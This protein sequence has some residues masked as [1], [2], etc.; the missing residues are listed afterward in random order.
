M[1]VNIEQQY[2]RT[3]EPNRIS[4]PQP[5]PTPNYRREYNEGYLSEKEPKIALIILLCV[6]QLMEA[7]EGEDA[8]VAA[9]LFMCHGRAR[10]L[11]V[12][13]I[14]LWVQPSL[15]KYKDKLR[16]T[17][18][19]IYLSTLMHL[20]PLRFHCVGGCWDRTQDCCDIGIGSQTLWPL[21]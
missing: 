8:R 14:L 15:M 13:N 20:P 3:F 2:S 1:Q 6:Q 11:C 21:G 17:F 18:F 16:S 7:G 9:L 10:V 4:P 19:S 5:P 12:H